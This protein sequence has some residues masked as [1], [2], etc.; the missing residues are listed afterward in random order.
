[1]SI[2]I[3]TQIA[4]SVRWQSFV[5]LGVSPNHV[6]RT[7]HESVPVDFQIGLLQLL[8]TVYRESNRVCS[9]RY[10]RVEANYMIGHER[11]VQLEMGMRDLASQFSPMVTST[12]ETNIA[13]SYQF[14]ALRCGGVVITASHVDELTERP[15][16]AIFRD[17]YAQDSQ[18]RLQF[19]AEP[20]TVPHTEDL[21]AIL[22]HNRRRDPNGSADPTLA[23]FIFP[24]IDGYHEAQIDLIADYPFHTDIPKSAPVEEIPDE[25]RA[26]LRRPNDN[27]ESESA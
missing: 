3:N 24:L 14:T 27:R 4:S 9:E 17:G 10:P 26:H 13:G 12:V 19:D 15:R 2:L 6:L 5:E 21:Y 22:V 16:K 1:M 23:R 25:L 18:K 20:I 8:V 11:R 7:F